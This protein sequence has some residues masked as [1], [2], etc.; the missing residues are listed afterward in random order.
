MTFRQLEDVATWAAENGG[1]DG[2]RNAVAEGRFGNDQRTV[3]LISEWIR[4]QLEATRSER[5]QRDIDLRV[6]E[7]TATES[8]A[9]SAKDSSEASIKSARW[10]LWAVVVAVVAL[11]VSMFK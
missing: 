3:S 9:K 6:R 2:L 5:E 4:L 11:L 7:V 1:V 10:A 8:A